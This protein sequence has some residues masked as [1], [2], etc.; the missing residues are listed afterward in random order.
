VL[1]R[2]SVGKILQMPLHTQIPAVMPAKGDR[3]NGAVGRVGGSQQLV[4]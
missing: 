4:S 1:N 2:V 3:L